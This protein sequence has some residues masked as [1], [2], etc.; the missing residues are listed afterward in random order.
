MAGVVKAGRL[1]GW[2]RPLTA[3]VAASIWGPSPSYNGG[4]VG[5]WYVDNTVSSSGDGTSEAEA[6]KTIAEAYAAKSVNDVILVRNQG[7]IPYREQLQL[8]NDTGFTLKRYGTE[9]PTISAFEILTG[10]TACVSGDQPVVGTGNHTNCYKTTLSQSGD[11]LTNLTADELDLFEDGERIPLIADQAAS[12]TIPWVQDDPR[13]FHTADAFNTDGVTGF[14]ESITDASVFTNY[15][16]A[17]IE[18]AFV[19]YLAGSNDGYRSD[20]LSFAANTATLATEEVAPDGSNKQW[21]LYNAG[22]L[23]QGS[24]CYRVSGDTITIY[25][26]PT[27]SANVTSGIEYSARE[28]VIDL[29]NADNFEMYGINCYGGASNRLHYGCAVGHPTNAVVGSHDNI[30]IK[31]CVFGRNRNLDNNRGC[32]YLSNDYQVIFENNTIEDAQSHALWC[33]RSNRAQIKHNLIQRCR[34]AGIR[35]DGNTESTPMI[36]AVI[37]RN[38]IDT[39]AYGIHQ[40][41][42]TLYNGMM[43]TVVAFNKIIA[44]GGYSTL[45]RFNDGIFWG[46]EFPSCDS[47]EGYRCFVDQ[48]EGGN[49]PTGDDLCYFYNNTCRPHPDDVAGGEAVDLGDATQPPVWYMANNILHGLR[50]IS[51]AP[52]YGRDERNLY[53]GSNSNWTILS[54]SET[55]TVAQTWDAPYTLTV[56]YLSGGAAGK[57]AVDLSSDITSLT[58]WYETAVNTALTLSITLGVDFTLD[59][60]G[61]TISNDYVGATYPGFAD[62]DAT[63]PTR[64]TF[65]PADEATDINVNLSEI[66]IDH[67]ER[68]TYGASKTITLYNNTL[69]S[70]IETFNTTSDQGTGAG[71]ISID[72]DKLKVRPTSALPGTTEISLGFDTGYVEDMNAN[73]A[74]A[75]AL[76][77]YTFTTAASG[78]NTVSFD[79]SVSLERDGTLTS[80]TD[81]K[82][83]TFYICFEPTRDSANE[84]LCNSDTN[85]YIA[86]SRTNTARFEFRAANASGVIATLLGPTDATVAN[87]RR[88]VLVTYDTANGIALMYVDGSSADSETPAAD[89]LIPFNSISDFSIM[90]IPG[91][92]AQSQGEIAAFYLVDQYYDITDSAVRD[93]FYNS[94]TGDPVMDGSLATPIVQFTGNAAAWSAGTNEGTGG[95]FVKKGAGTISDV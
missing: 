46:N 30:I 9:I 7:D 43:N 63:A 34:G 33:G 56:D 27:D 75:L 5:D 64:G 18:A 85:Y 66:T 73:Q 80:T 95:T 24:W 47:Y 78:F 70:N 31:H 20:I 36:G 48:N 91:P 51:G 86:M 19:R 84:R 57:L 59:C 26:Y 71:T 28:Y 25:V 76:G 74:S 41:V 6:F 69:A 22:N 39:C 60:N 62:T 89:E 13:T 29:A 82:E 65:T 32:V 83:L 61:D 67:S 45:Q 81:G 4:T 44:N 2:N 50:R 17:Q 35:T 21:A 8:T 38:K 94:G 68:V 37:E 10:L 54:T 52:T 12:G 14:V 72:D 93:L 15:S 40:N 58:S 11:L 92:S 87:G 88:N 23:T 90:G 16:T 49:V 53:T 55:A 79:G 77:T 42:L 3:S 1:L